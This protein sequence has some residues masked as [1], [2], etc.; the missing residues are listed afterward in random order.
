MTPYPSFVLIFDVE[1]KRFIYTGD[2]KGITA[3]DFPEVAL[4]EQSDLIITESAHFKV[5]TILEKAL[6]CPT[7]SVAIT[8]IY[9]PDMKLVLDTIKNT[10]KNADILVFAPNDGDVIEL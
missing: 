10:N 3:E 5:E 6:S 7:K 4:K 8:H 1:G 2:L 9:S